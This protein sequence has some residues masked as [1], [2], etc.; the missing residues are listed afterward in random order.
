MS[1]SIEEYAEDAVVAYLNSKLTT[2]LLAVYTAWTDTEIK[3][4]CVVVHAG[5]SSNVTGQ[6]NGV[7]RV[8]MSL[9]VMSEVIT[10]GVLSA[11]VANRTYRDA[12]IDA[13]AQTNL[14]A[15]INALSPAGVVFSHAEVGDITRSVEDNK[16]MF[17]SEITLNCIA[18]PKAIT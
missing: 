10:Q 2:N 11:R 5:E 12:V 13:L 4:P 8:T 16:R 18:A 14:E 7:R 6:F 1:W 15:D 17:V 3:Y 9:A